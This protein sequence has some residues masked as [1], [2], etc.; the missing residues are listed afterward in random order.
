[1]YST[2]Q[3][4][5]NLTILIAFHNNLKLHLAANF[6]PTVPG[7]MERYSSEIQGLGTHLDRLI[8]NPLMAYGPRGSGKPMAFLGWLEPPTRGLTY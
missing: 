6:T 8:D 4:V 3:A 1:M 2:T 5:N 7:L